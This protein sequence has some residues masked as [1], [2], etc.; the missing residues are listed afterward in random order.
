M[1]K[2]KLAHRALSFIF[3]FAVA[4]SIAAV[5]PLTA[6]A[7]A[8]DKTQQQAVD[9][10]KDQAKNNNQVMECAVFTRHYLEWL[11]NGTSPLS[12]KSIP[13][14]ISY[15]AQTMP[16]ELQKLGAD[17]MPQAG[18]I[19]VFNNGKPTGH[20]GVAISSDRMVD[21][22]NRSGN[23][24]R[25]PNEHAI[26]TGGTI[27]GIIRPT[28]EVAAPSPTPSASANILNGTYSIV[29]D[30]NFALDIADGKKDSGDYVQIWQWDK[31][32]INQ[33]F[34]LERQGDT[35]KITAAVSGKV[36]DIERSNKDNGAN[37]LQWD[38]NGGDNQKWYIVDAGGGYYKFVA[39]HSGKC[40]DIKGGEFKN[41]T[42][43]WQYEDNGTISQKFKLVPL[44]VLPDT[45]AG[46]ANGRYKIQNKGSGK[47][48]DV[49]GSEMASGK[50]VHLWENAT[51]LNQQ[52]DFLRLPDNTYKI[53]AAHS[54]KVLDVGGGGKDDGVNVQQYDWNDTASQHWFVVDCGGGYYKLIAKVSGK[55]LDV[56]GGGKDNGTNIQQYRDNGTDAQRFKLIPASAGAAPAPATPSTPGYAKLSGEYKIVN[57]S[58]GKYLNNFGGDK[59]GGRITASNGDGSIEQNW[60]ISVY[61][62]DKHLIRSLQGSKTR[63]VDVACSGTADLDSG[64]ITHMW[65]Q[66]PL[67]SKHW[68]FEP[69]GNNTY[70]I[71][72]ALNENLVLAV[73]TNEHRSDVIVQT[74]SGA[75]AQKWKLTAS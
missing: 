71:R 27:A 15:L 22:N 35:Y 51:G 54:G 58:G 13:T 19:I 39:K 29:A 12:G 7:A 38:S 20:A 9:W 74:Y 52:W 63:V 16:S 4:F 11:G 21:A 18:D 59:N 31:N 32:S 37:V 75:D 57:V 33:Q 42:D 69:L 48:V 6:N 73:R 24:N 66:T 3:A 53:T 61:E 17:T 36:I 25:S 8:I 30:G 56:G 44:A 49:A 68:Y 65:S 2:H 50:N 45:S 60:A 62:G 5:A 1:S 70:V 14:A 26:S 64:D 23:G 72:N 10:A 41:G 55:A 67:D 34:H 28:L 46:I 40:L 43:I 47:Y